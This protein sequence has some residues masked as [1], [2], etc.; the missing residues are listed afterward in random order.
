MIGVSSI[1]PESP[2]PILTTSQ[3]RLGSLV[4]QLQDPAGRPLRGY[5]LVDRTPFADVPALA[6][7]TS[8]RGEVRCEGVQPVKHRVE[9]MPV[10]QTFSDLGKDEEPF[11]A[12][13]DLIGR[14]IVE[15]REVTTP[16]GEETRLTMCARPAGYVRGTLRP[17]AGRTPADYNIVCDGWHEVLRCR[18]HYN[19]KTGEFVLGPWAEGKHTLRVF[20]SARNRPTIS[21][22]A[23]KRTSRATGSCKLT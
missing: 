20:R 21:R 9:V 2:I 4:I 12:D 15:S 17:P 19:K 13:K 11:P 5:V 18:V 22:Q 10:G 3:R 14:M 23:K 16:V 8:Q 7:T 1:L 6:G